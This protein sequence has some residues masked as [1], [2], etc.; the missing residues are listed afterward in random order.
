MHA[1]GCVCIQFIKAG[2]LCSL[3]DRQP[4]G[5]ATPVHSFSV[6]LW[7]AAKGWDGCVKIGMEKIQLQPRA[8]QQCL[9]EAML[10]LA[11]KPNVLITPL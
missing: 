8:K 4:I 10:G 1:H 2:I 3:P 11:P 9:K 5:R 6:G 7:W